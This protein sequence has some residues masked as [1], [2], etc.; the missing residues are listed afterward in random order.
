[1]SISMSSASVPVFTHMLGNLSH[2]LDKAQTYIDEKGCD[3]V[4]LTQFRLA[5]DMLPFTGQILIACDA[6]KNGVARISGVEAPKFA[7]TEQTIA[8]LKA[9]IQKTRDYLATVPAAALDGTEDKD[10]TFPVGR[11]RTRTMKAEDYLKLWVLPNMF[12]HITTAY[13]IL[14]H[15]GVPVGKQDYLVGGQG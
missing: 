11:E 6:A 8:E 12:F 9:R 10:I 1:M 2:L 4:A 15:N 3:P 7:D 13:A 5:P 14:R